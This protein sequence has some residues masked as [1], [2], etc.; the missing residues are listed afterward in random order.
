MDAGDF[1]QGRPA[2]E[3]RTLCRRCHRNMASEACFLVGTEQICELCAAKDPRA[4]PK[5][6]LPA[7]IQTQEDPHIREV[8][9]APMPSIHA[10]APRPWMGL[11]G[12]SDVTSD[13]DAAADSLAAG[14]PPIQL[15][16]IDDIRVWCSEAS[17]VLRLPVLALMVYWMVQHFTDTQY[18]SVFDG[19]NLGIHELGHVV[20]EPFGALLHILGGTILQC[21]APLI[22]AYVLLR[23]RDYFGISFIGCWFATNLYDVAVYVGDARERALPLVGL[24]SGEP[25]HDWY[26]LLGRFG[27]L[28]SDQLIAAGLR[29]LG[30]MSFLVSIAFGGWLLIQMTRRHA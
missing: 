28:R 22:G 18:S 30:M 1:Q 27:L 17:W 26:Y 6:A 25:M 15:S 13:A 5:A 23:Q 10:P 7:E 29:S 8:R 24:G 16:R 19:I 20:F 9:G 4:Q 3:G 21:A 12:G 11:S 2:A 14:R